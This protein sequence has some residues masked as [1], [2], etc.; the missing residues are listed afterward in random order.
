MALKMFKHTKSKKA[1]MSKGGVDHK[2]LPS[3][4][5]DSEES[6]LHNMLNGLP[7]AQQLLSD[8]NNPQDWEDAQHG[9]LPLRWE[10]HAGWV[11]T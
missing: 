8:E 9:R 4:I 6:L 3:R 11:A 1:K 10:L 5:Q 7:T 2:T